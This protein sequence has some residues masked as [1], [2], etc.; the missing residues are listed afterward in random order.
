MDYFRVV[1][2]EKFQHYKNRN[3][4]WIKLHMSILTNY[5]FNQLSDT[6]KY[7]LIG[8]Y[9]LAARTANRIPMD[10]R[11]IRDSLRM[12]TRKV[13]LKKLIGLKLIE[14]IQDDGL[15]NAS[16]VLDGRKHDTPPETET[17]TETEEDAP[18][19]PQGADIPFR[20]LFE[21]AWESFPL[22][23]QGRNVRSRA[24]NQWKARIN[25]GDDPN[26]IIKA[27]KNYAKSRE[28]EDDQFTISLQRFIGKERHFTNWQNLDKTKTKGKEKTGLFKK[29]YGAGLPGKGGPDE[30]G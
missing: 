15:D 16:K 14:Q 11:Y 30:S 3:P 18:L 24:E 5:E 10:T 17:E 22:V 2:F 26:I 4:P 13:Q 1:N 9:L 29:N 21:I 6:E 8:L 19:T 27:V 20:D 7:L 23:I 12:T 28:K 25:G